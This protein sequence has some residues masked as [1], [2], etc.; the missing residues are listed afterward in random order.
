MPF[1]YALGRIEPRFPKLSVEKEFAQALGREDMRGQSDRQALSS[2]LS[3]REYR[4]IARQM[5][6]AFSIEGLDTYLLFPRDPG[7]LDLFIESLRPTPSPIDIDAV[8]GVRGP[9]APP[10]LCN[11]L[12]V[13]MVVVD[14]LY[15]FDR[16]A[17]IAAVPLPSRMK[18]DEEQFRAS[19][20]ELLDRILQLADNAGATPEDRALNYLALRYPAIYEKMADEFA[21]NASLSA[22]DVRP[23]TL[24]STRRVVE[25]I[26]SFRNRQT[27]VVEKSFVRV[28]VTEEFPFLV[29]KLSP[30]YD[31]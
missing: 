27:D 9:V 29:T 17:L 1:V 25:V 28:D 2:I 3:K 14:H 10:D 13:P 7:D 4:Y 6:W 20:A 12:T 31:R 18:K 16:D 26:F 19:A 24:A 5:C 21:A 22:V 30:Y 15:S 23:S 11:G 8:I